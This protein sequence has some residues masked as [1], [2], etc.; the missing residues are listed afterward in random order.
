MDEYA[1]FLIR[2]FG[3]DILE[4]LAKEKLKFKQFKIAELE[5]ITKK[6]QIN[7]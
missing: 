6:Y 7:N 1:R 5:E 3:P 4:D 2:K